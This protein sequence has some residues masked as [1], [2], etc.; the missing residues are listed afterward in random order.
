M[1]SS[2]PSSVISSTVPCSST[3]AR[4]VDSTSSLLRL[5]S[6]SESNPSLSKRSDNSNPAGPAPIMPTCVRFFIVRFPFT[7]EL[8]AFFCPIYQYILF[9]GQPQLCSDALMNTK[10]SW[11]GIAQIKTLAII[12]YFGHHPFCG[13]YKMEFN[14]I[15]RG[16]FDNVVQCLLCYTM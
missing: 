15:R 3:P 13:A 2:I 7:P 5:S 11:K 6:T 14:V 12:M 4:M 1:R 10:M 8:H 9:V 16:M